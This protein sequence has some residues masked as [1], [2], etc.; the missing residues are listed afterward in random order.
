MEADSKGSRRSGHHGQWFSGDMRSNGSAMEVKGSEFTCLMKSLFLVI[1]V[2]N[3]FKL[4][5][6]CSFLLGFFLLF[7]ALFLSESLINLTQASDCSAIRK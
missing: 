7:F 3:S 5:L 2:S 1:L 4:F 6:P